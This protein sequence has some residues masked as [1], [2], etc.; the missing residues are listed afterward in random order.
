MTNHKGSDAERAQYEKL[1]GRF[2]LANGA[3]PTG[4]EIWQAAR[5]PGD[6][7]PVAIPGWKLVPVEPTPEILQAMKTFVEGGSYL[8]H[9]KVR[10]EGT[11]N[12]DSPSAW[13][14]RC[15]VALYADILS[16]ATAPTLVARQGSEGL[17]K[18]G[19]KTGWPPGL[20]QDD[21]K[22]LSKW[23]SSKPDAKQVVRDNIKPHS[24]GQ[25]VES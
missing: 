22:G 24:G 23:L 14:D 20:L 5:A 17:S 18:N 3:Y 19:G 25:G 6:A 1:V 11:E 21:S 7:R 2:I 8:R 16:A 15:R 9:P 12:G 13:M 10:Y 4:F